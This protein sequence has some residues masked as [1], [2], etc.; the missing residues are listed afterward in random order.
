[1]RNWLNL[2][3][4]MQT[5]DEGDY[6]QQEGIFRDLMDECRIEKLD[7]VGKENY[8]KYDLKEE[9]FFECWAQNALFN[10]K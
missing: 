1:M 5:M 7:T 8:K 6:L 3:K 4:N 10:L 9:R 2:L